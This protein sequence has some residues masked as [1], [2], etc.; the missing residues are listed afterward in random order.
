MA[1]SVIAQWRRALTEQNESASTSRPRESL[2]DK[3]AKVAEQPFV[4]QAMELFDVPAGQFRYTP[5]ETDAS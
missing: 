5:P 2:R 3:K 1:D 4:R